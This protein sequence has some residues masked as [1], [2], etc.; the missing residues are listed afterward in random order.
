[1]PSRLIDG[2]KSCCSSREQARACLPSGTRDTVGVD[3]W[4][5]RSMDDRLSRAPRTSLSRFSTA[6]HEWRLASHRS[7]SMQP[8][9]M[10]QHRLDVTRPA[11]DARRTDTS[12]SVRR[13]QCVSLLF[14]LASAAL[15]H[16]NIRASSAIVGLV[17]ADNVGIAGLPRV[18]GRALQTDLCLARCL[19]IWACQK[20]NSC[21]WSHH[22]IGQRNYEE[23]KK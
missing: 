15:Y 3:A 9:D 4:L 10:E 5:R 21:S 11:L 2:A 18:R 23:Q 14:V 16:L 19:A 22:I 8:G 6:G 1:M 7:V 13:V 20:Q 12:S 17:S